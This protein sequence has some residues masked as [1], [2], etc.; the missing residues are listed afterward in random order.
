MTKPSNISIPANRFKAL[1]Q[2]IPRAPDSVSTDRLLEKLSAAGF[3]VDLRTLQRNL[4][5]LVES[6]EFGLSSEKNGRE[7]ARWQYLAATPV[8]MF[9]SLDD[10][11]ALAF[12]LADAFLQ[13][14][15]PPE[16]VKALRPFVEEAGRHLSKRQ[17]AAAGKWQDKIHV[18]PQGMRRKP[19]KIRPEVREVVYRALLEE[20]PLR[21]VHH[22]RSSPV[23]KE[24]FISPVGLVVRDYM[25][26]LY[27]VTREKKQVLAFAL[28]RTQHA[29]ILEEAIFDKPPPGFTLAES[30]ELVS[31]PYEGSK[32]INLSLRIGKISTYSLRECP[33]AS[34]QALI[35]D[36]E[37]PE[38]GILTAT[39]PNTV[40]LRQWIRSLGPDTEVLE[41]TFL[42]SEIAEEIA[43]L[44]QRYGCHPGV[45]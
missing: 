32:H 33:L 45:N 43:L 4:R 27:G 34:R 13:S 38:G 39:V 22:S 35:P 36:A 42:R 2:M 20:M 9:P 26:Y 37:N 5:D 15:M 19:P 10:H 14:L 44:A 40:E 3:E 23:P 18:F 1:L 8:T 7:S 12:R 29:E 16:T 31:K 21:L 28:N 17:Q 30:E 24:F 25:I 41:P 6:G 11:T